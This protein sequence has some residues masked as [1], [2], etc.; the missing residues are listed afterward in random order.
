[1]KWSN[2]FNGYTFIVNKNEV[3][4]ISSFAGRTVKGK[5]RCHPKDNFNLEL[6]KELAAARCGRKI[7]EKRYKRAR[8]KYTDICK[9]VL[10][11][12]N[13]FTDTCEYLTNAYNRLKEADAELEAVRDKIFK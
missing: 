2:K 7:A 4:A 13:E 10:A 6:G 5:A 1:M 9:V 3:I 11:V 12:N 8:E